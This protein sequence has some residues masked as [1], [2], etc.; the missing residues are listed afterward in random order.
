MN[1]PEKEKRIEAMSPLEAEMIAYRLS[2]SEWEYRQ[3]LEQFKDNVELWQLQQIQEY[4][5]EN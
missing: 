1:V 4:L 5:D 3:K 2:T